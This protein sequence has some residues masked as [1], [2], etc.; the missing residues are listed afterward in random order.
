VE[1]KR[2]TPPLIEAVRGGSPAAGVDEDES[3]WW[4]G[5]D[6]EEIQGKGWR[7]DWRRRGS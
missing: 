3:R 5:A 4:P 7:G 6:G 1:V 2:R